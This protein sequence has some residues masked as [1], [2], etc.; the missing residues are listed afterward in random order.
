MP[1]TFSV[2]ERSPLSALPLNYW[3]K[4]NASVGI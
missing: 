4:A 1:A 2:P 3:R